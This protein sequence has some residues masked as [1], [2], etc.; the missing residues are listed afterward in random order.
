MMQK[1]CRLPVIGKWQC[2][3]TFMTGMINVAY[4]VIDGV[5]VGTA[6]GTGAIIKSAG[7]DLLR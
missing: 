3:L 1:K 4:C 6:M 5:V 2:M 7:T